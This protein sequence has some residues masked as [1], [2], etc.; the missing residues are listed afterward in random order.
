VKGEGEGKA[1][2]RCYEMMITNDPS[3]QF[4][5][6]AV[7]SWGN[8]IQF[9]HLEVRQWIDRMGFVPY[10]SSLSKHIMT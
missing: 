10:L 6:V 7:E 1:G 2:G 5:M 9:L 8:M 4:A 3:I